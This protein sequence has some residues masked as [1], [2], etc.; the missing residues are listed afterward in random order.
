[1]S[2]RVGTPKLDNYH[3]QRGD[4]RHFTSGS[5]VVIEDSPLALKRRLWS[6]TDKTYRLAAERLIK[7]RTNTEV[8]V[9]EEDQSDDFSSEPPS[10]FSEPPPQAR[11]PAT[12]GRRASVSCPRSSANIRAS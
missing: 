6:D 12:S 1:M 4:R 7:I 10:V 8:K 2:V 3:L 5:A 11:S 9:R